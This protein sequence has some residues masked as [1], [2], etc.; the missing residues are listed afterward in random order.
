MAYYI[1]ASLEKTI[2]Q[3]IWSTRT[4]MIKL[5]HH[6][7]NLLF[8]WQNLHKSIL[9][10]S[11]LTLNVLQQGHNFRITT[12]RDL[13][14]YIKKTFHYLFHHSFSPSSINLLKSGKFQHTLSTLHKEI[15]FFCASIPFIEPL[16]TS[17]LTA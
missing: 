3:V 17:F 2:C 16:N 6:L 1:P 12:S 9:F 15:Q 4:I 10:L 7:S 13:Y 5:K 14:F 8:I 11:N